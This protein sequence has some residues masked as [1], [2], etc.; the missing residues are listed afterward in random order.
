VEKYCR[1]GQTTDNEMVHA[2]FMPDACG[3]KHTL[4]LGSARCFSTATMVA[5]TRSELSYKYI[6]LP[7]LFRLNHN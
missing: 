4:R 7:I 3:Y 1:A 5:Q 2:S 6:T